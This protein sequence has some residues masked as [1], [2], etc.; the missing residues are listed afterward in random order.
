MAKLMTIAGPVCSPATI[1][2]TENKPAPMMTPT[3]SAMSPHAPSTRFSPF[4]PSF[5]ASCSSSAAVFLMN[6]SMFLLVCVSKLSAK[7]AKCSVLTKFCVSSRVN[8]SVRFLRNS[9]QERVLWVCEIRKSCCETKNGQKHG[10]TV[11]KSR[12]TL[13]LLQGVFI[14]TYS[15]TQDYGVR[16]VQRKFFERSLFHHL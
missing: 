11:T 14:V 8:S 10:D 16:S 5:S 9:H 4:P 7:L 13:L 12:T 15:L 1:P 6:K 2:V 3:P